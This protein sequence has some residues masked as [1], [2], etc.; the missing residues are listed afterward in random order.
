MIRSLTVTQLDRFTWHASID[1]RTTLD[2]APNPFGCDATFTGPFAR[3]R[4][5][6]SGMREIRRRQRRDN[7]R[8][9]R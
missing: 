6:R 7:Y 1:E 4:A 8:T 5:T 2:A 3:A 9:T